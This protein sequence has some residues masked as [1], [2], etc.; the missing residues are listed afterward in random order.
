MAALE[1]SSK[2]EDSSLAKTAIGV[3][4][5]GST[6]AR[7]NGLIDGRKGVGR[8]ANGITIETNGL[9]SGRQRVVI[10]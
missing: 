6:R 8:V 7:L 5:E 10:G 2:K 3:G 1:S 4:L 9:I